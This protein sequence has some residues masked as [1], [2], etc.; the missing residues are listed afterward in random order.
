MR[1]YQMKDLKLSLKRLQ[2]LVQGLN[3]VENSFCCRVLCGFA[4]CLLNFCLTPVYCSAAGEENDNIRSD[5]L[6]ANY[7]IASIANKS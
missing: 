5:E 2:F 7:G 3:G 4:N 1:N 6:A